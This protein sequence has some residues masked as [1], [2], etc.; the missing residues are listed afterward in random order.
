MVSVAARDPDWAWVQRGELRLPGEGLTLEMRNGLRGT[1]DDREEYE[2][3]ARLVRLDLPDRAPILA[4]MTRT[5]PNDSLPDSSPACSISSNSDELDDKETLRT[6][7]TLHIRACA[8]NYSL[9]SMGELNLSDGIIGEMELR[10]FRKSSISETLV[11][12]RTL[13]VYSNRLVLTTPVE[14]WAVDDNTYEENTDAHFRIPVEWQY[15]IG[16]EYA[17]PNRARFLSWTWNSLRT[18]T[19]VGN[20]P[21]DDGDADFRTRCSNSGASQRPQFLNVQNAAIYKMGTGGSRPFSIET[22]G[23]QRGRLGS[24]FAPLHAWG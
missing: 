18:T 5:N 6:G 14:L 19:K 15:P 7:D 23:R 13:T 12:T 3:E 8:V 24:G 4:D 17:V 11:H 1:Y 9:T 2:Y 16:D 21:L 20:Y 10:I 22:C